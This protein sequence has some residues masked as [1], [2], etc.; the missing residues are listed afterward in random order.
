MAAAAARIAE[1]EAEL[2]AKDAALRIAKAQ[3]SQ[4]SAGCTSLRQ[5][6]MAAELRAADALDARDVAETTCNSA[7]LELQ[8]LRSE[9]ESAKTAAHD[10]EQVAAAANWRAEVMA[11]V[12][13]EC[14]FD[15]AQAAALP[16]TAVRTAVTAAGRVAVRTAARTDAAWRRPLLLLWHAWA[17]N[18][19]RVRSSQQREAVRRLRCL[20]VC[21]CRGAFKMWLH[22]AVGLNWAPCLP[23][24]ERSSRLALKVIVRGQNSLLDA[25]CR[26]AFHTWNF[27]ARL[28]KHARH[29]ALHED[30]YRAFEISVQALIG[31]TQDAWWIHTV[32]GSWKNLVCAQAL[33]RVCAS[34]SAGAREAPFG[35]KATR[36]RENQRSHSRARMHVL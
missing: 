32:I 22:Y 8:E 27:H 7:E 33:E 11:S 24:S 13:G 21:R 16:C 31:A 18:A 15:M 12:L 35:M 25:L 1:L 28:S 23:E 14:R 34:V 19:A 4:W 17:F 36:P 20:F 30:R 2:S 10:A 3:C 26:G 9:V 29:S 6:L 5:G